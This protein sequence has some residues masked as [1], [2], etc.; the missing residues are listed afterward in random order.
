MRASISPS[1]A[2]LRDSRDVPTQGE[3]KRCVSQSEAV[4]TVSPEPE[5][6]KVEPGRATVTLE[7]IL[8]ALDGS[9][10]SHA[11]RISGLT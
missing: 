11:Q 2:M 6:V 1:A 3:G 5:I 7:M 10:I 8:V 4:A 9:V